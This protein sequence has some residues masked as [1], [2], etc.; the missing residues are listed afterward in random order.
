MFA[1]SFLIVHGYE[2]LAPQKHISKLV[3]GKTEKAYQQAWLI[4][5]HLLIQLESNP[6]KLPRYEI[7]QPWR[8]QIHLDVEI[9]N[10]S[11]RHTEIGEDH[12]LICYAII[13]DKDDGLLREMSYTTTDYQYLNSKD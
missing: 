1:A 8:Y 7:D 2:S 9:R 4:P 13:I 3:T 12:H 6:D 11:A 10:R 5:S